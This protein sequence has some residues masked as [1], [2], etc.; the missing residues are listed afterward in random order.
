[1]SSIT[2]QLDDIINSALKDLAAESYEI[3]CPNCHE[4]VEV[5]DGANKCP[6]CGTTLNVTINIHR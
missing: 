5:K 1:M 3:E 4:Q 6:N 2:K